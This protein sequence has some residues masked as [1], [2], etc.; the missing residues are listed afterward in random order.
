MQPRS[1]Y[2]ADT[3]SQYFRQSVSVGLNHIVARG[4]S[5]RSRDV[6]YRRQDP[7]RHCIEQVTRIDPKDIV[8]KHVNES[9]QNLIGIL[10]GDVGRKR[11]RGVSSV[12]KKR[13]K[14]KRARVII[15]DI[16][17]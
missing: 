4:Q 6:A 8:S 12:T 7:N 15:R 1:T 17:S 16:F 13:K 5:C 3:G 10:R 2:N 14:A 9:V 11:A